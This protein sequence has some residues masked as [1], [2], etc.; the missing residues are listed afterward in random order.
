[1]A[2]SGKKHV[3]ELGKKIQACC[4]GYS[5][6]TVVHVMG[7]TFIGLVYGFCRYDEKQALLIIDAYV[8]NAMDILKRGDHEQ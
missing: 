7:A 6:R 1:M 5:N 8:K 3:I 4:E 2:K